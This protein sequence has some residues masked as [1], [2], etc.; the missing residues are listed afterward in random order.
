MHCWGD[1]ATGQL[2]DGTTADRTSP[3]AVVWR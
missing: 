2:G 3:V 1:N